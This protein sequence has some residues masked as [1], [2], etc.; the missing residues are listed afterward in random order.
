MRKMFSKLPS[1]AMVVALIALVA[2]GA[3]T[4]GLPW[5]YR[6]ASTFLSRAP[7]APARPAAPTTRGAA[8]AAGPASR[9]A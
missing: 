9:G 2:A 7:R 1:P 5:L 4:V 3:L 6:R 8:S